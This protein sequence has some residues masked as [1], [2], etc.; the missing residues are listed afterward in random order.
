[1][2]VADTQITRLFLR[3]FLLLPENLCAAPTTEDMGE[4]LKIR[5]FIAWQNYLGGRGCLRELHLDSI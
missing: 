5:S 1:M 4:L 3:K 2:E